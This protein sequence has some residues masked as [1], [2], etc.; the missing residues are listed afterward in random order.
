M[1]V[2]KDRAWPNHGSLLIARSS[3]TGVSK[4]QHAHMPN[5]FI[6]STGSTELCRFLRTY[7]TSSVRQ[8]CV[9]RTTHYA[10]SLR[11]KNCSTVLSCAVFYA[12]IVHLYSFVLKEQHTWRI[13]LRTKHWFYWAVQF[14]TYVLLHVMLYRGGCSRYRQQV[15]RLM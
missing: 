10:E 2:E 1:H 11:M 9:K 4:E 15:P 6:G 12:L 3:N 14:F 13:V 5:R 7:C 8:F